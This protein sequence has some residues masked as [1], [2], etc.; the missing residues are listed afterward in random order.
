MPQY[1]E[2][3]NPAQREAVTTLRGPLL[4]VAGAGSG[5]TRV[6]TYRIAHLLEN[7]IAPWNILALTFTN[8]AAREMKERIANVVGEKVAGQLW[9]GTFHSIFLRILRIEAETLG[10]S[11]T[12]SVYDTSASQGAIA[13]IIKEMNLSTDDYAPRRIASRISMA[14]NNL[15]LPSQYL[16]EPLIVEQDSRSKIPRTGEIYEAYQQSLRRASAMDFDDLL[17][18]MTLLLGHYPEIRQRYQEKFA[19][20]LVDEYQD[21]NVVQNRILNQL[22]EQHH[23]LCVVGDDAQSIYAFRGAKIQNIIKFPSTYPELK[24]VKLETNYRSTGAIVE[25]AN[26]LIAHNPNQIRKVCRA[27]TDGGDDIEISTAFT[28]MEE[29][30]FVAQHIQT[31]A[32]REKAQHGQFAILYRTNAQSRLL[33]TGLRA[34]NIPYRV[35]GGT[36]FYQRKEVQDLLAYFRLVA[37]P[38]DEQALLRVINLPARGIGATTLAA[39]AAGANAREVSLW[40]YLQDIE[41]T[42]ISLRA[43]TL[44]A[45]VQFRE[46]IKGFLGR[47]HTAE[48]YGLAEEI[49]RKSGLRE[50]LELDTTP[51]GESRVGNVGEVFNSIKEFSEAKVESGETDLVTLPMYLD[52]VSLLTDADKEEEGENERVTLSTIHSAKGLEYD[53]VYVVGLEENI[54]P[55]RR[56]SEEP[57]GL[58]EERRLCYVAVTRAAKHLT[59]THALSRSTYGQ[60]QRN[61]QSRF[62]GEIVPGYHAQGV[63]YLPANS[64][65]GSSAWRGGTG[66]TAQNQRLNPSVAKPRGATAPAAINPSAL[67]EPAT[68]PEQLSAGDSVLHPR[69]G[70]GEILELQQQGGDPRAIVQFINEPKPRT[71]VLRYAQLRKI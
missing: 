4:I 62:L 60:S 11:P 22:A 42:A 50:A 61:P 66:R 2:T 51:E 68:P 24:M 63:E 52:E 18:Q 56:A 71:L 30:N 1:L 15:V 65:T 16:N 13:R 17:L 20:I 41:R 48:A 9:M 36:S 7:G 69:F 53:Y 55:S 27:S 21:T 37:N 6:L 3:L 34:L 44:G 14:K 10:Y 32:L 40:D 58:E 29:A 67:R 38:A 31:T 43:A 70:R 25:A 26:R 57:G 28:D 35:Y 54:F 49:Y 8:K 47:V 12:F 46:L 5:K 59:L 64:S 33:E 19:Y 39:L 23:N 45:I